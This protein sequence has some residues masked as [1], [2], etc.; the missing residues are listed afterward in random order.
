MTT[1][2]YLKQRDLDGLADGVDMG[3]RLL[4]QH[5]PFWWR[6]VDPDRLNMGS[7]S[8]C[9]LG[10]LY[11]SFSEGLEVVCNFYDDPADYGFTFCL[12][13]VP[14]ELSS[15]QKDE[16]TDEQLAELAR[17]WRSLIVQRL[18]AEGENQDPLLVTVT[19]VRRLQ[20]KA[21][22]L[23]QRVQEAAA[24]RERAAQPTPA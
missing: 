7:P 9:V 8:C 11:G 20:A 24:A 12:E 19:E 10:Q 14:E 2:R 21:A 22:A 15:N 4:D 6:D 5:R 16:Q 18:Q 1:Y 17:L 13:E 3:V 23:E